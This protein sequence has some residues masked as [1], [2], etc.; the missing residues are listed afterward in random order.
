[1]MK[2]ILNLGS[3]EAIQ[4]LRNLTIGRW[5]L[6]VILI[7]ERPCPEVTSQSPELT[8]TRWFGWHG[9]LYRHFHINRERGIR[10]RLTNAR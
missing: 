3:K 4:D 2:Y 7:A 5:F 8:L 10:I 1:M 6:L 9:A